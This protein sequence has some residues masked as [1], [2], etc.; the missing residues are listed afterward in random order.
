L[1]ADSN[2]DTFVIEMIACQRRLYAYVL[3]IVFDKDRAR[4]IVQ[5]TNLVLLQKKS[6]FELG[7]SFG[8][9]ACRVAFYEILADRRRTQRSRN[10]F[11]DEMILNLADKAEIAAENADRRIEALEA[12]LEN[13]AVDHR[14]LL[15]QRYSPGGSVADIAAASNK[16]PASISSLLYRIRCI[17]VQCIEG[18][19]ERTSLA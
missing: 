1:S 9:W 8:A 18:K 17:L 5:N 10:I 2:D 11:D 12:C 15:Q 16:S 3:S 4:E 14:Q 7:T 13:L 6:E 19:L